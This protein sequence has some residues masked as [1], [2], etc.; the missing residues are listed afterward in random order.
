MIKEDLPTSVIV[1]NRQWVNIHSKIAVHF[2]Y[3]ASVILRD[4]HKTLTLWD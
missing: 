2:H 4:F 3:H 1:S